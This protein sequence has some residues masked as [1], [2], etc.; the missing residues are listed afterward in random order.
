MIY[1]VDGNEIKDTKR[2]QNGRMNGINKVVSC[3]CIFRLL[4][5]D[6]QTTDDGWSLM[7]HQ[8]G[9]KFR[10]GVI[11]SIESKL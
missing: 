6:L 2:R 5:R 7:M 8:E 1:D 11:L 10:K 3:F 9:A 4:L